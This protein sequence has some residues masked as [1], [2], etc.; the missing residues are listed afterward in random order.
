[1]SIF[2]VLAGG[3]KNQDYLGSNPYYS[4]GANI[5]Q[6]A[7]PRAE[8][9]AQALAFPLLQGL[10][11]GG[12]VG[13]GKNQAT[14]A[15]YQDASNSP[16]L[17]AL[18]TERPASAAFG[19][20][21]EEAA[22]QG[23]IQKALLENSGVKNIYGQAKAPEG[24]TP[25]TGKQDLLMALVAKQTLAESEAKKQAIKDEIASKYGPDVLKYN[26][27]LEAAKAD[28]QIRVEQAKA[29]EQ[30]KTE[31]DT[32]NELIPATVPK[33]LR[34]AAASEL[35]PRAAREQVL[36]MADKIYDS[37]D[38]YKRFSGMVPTAAVTNEFEINKAKL[39]LAAQKNMGT[40]PGPLVLKQLETALP[41]W[42]DT[43]EHKRLKRE[44]LK[45]LLET[46]SKP[47]PILD[48]FAPSSRPK[49]SPGAAPATIPDIPMGMKLIRNKNTGE[50]KLVPQ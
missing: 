24:F 23:A 12:L 16:L 15:A 46:S 28:E 43:A 17:S 48:R 27:D 44:Q 38:K 13:Y 39:K 45:D 33:S 42:D 50:T 18:T 9:N 35:G 29:D 1:M 26:K 8:T 25:E 40:E 7:M 32:A 14:E 6:S 3:I 37:A 41:D 49:P 2:D 36:G 10:I 5:L 31:G 4:A 22:Q 20:L 47:T 11:G 30:R 34:A 19:P 21:T